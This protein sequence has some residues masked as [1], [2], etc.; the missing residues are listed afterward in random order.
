MGGPYSYIILAKAGAV[1]LSIMGLISSRS[2]CVTSPG[3]VGSN[4]LVPDPT[5][6]R[7]IGETPA[8]DSEGEPERNSRGL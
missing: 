8:R 4:R 2:R 1:A 7:S 6:H 3:W 5:Y